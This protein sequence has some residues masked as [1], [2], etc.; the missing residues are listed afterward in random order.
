MIKKQNHTTNLLKYFLWRCR[1]NEAVDVNIDK[2]GHQELTIETVHDTTVTGDDV[3]KVLK[4]FCSG[5][6]A[7]GFHLKRIEITAHN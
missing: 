7:I 3:T 6:V 1:S 5:L 2:C 4:F